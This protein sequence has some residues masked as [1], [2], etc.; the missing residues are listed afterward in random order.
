V[1]LRTGK[2][3]LKARAEEEVEVKAEVRFEA[4]SIDS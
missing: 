1:E 4:K 3:K 2:K